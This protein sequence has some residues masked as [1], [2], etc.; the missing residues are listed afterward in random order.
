[1]PKINNL[2]KTERL[3]QRIQQLKE[4]VDVAIREINSLLSAQQQQLLND[5]W[6]EHLALRETNELAKSE[7]KTIREIR[8]EVLTSVLDEMHLNALEDIQHLQHKTEVKAAKVFLDAYFEA[9]KNGKNAMSS[10]KIALQRNHFNTVKK[11]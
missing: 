9:E 7:Y 10:A 2:H 4:G 3:Q 6:Q 11:R 5:T 8:I 1:M